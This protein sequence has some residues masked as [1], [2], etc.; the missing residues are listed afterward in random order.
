MTAQHAAITADDIDA[1]L[2]VPL[3]PRIAQ[4]AW[5]QRLTEGGEPT[6]D[7][8]MLCELACER[9]PAGPTATIR[10]LIEGLLIRHAADPATT[11]A[12]T[13][14]ACYHLPDLTDA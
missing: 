6:C 10:G 9:D 8:D 1:A 12:L 4:T 5:V 2:A 14:I 7:D 3:G 13:A 11:A